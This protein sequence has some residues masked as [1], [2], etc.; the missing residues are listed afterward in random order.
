MHDLDCE[1]TNSENC[2]YDSI[3]EDKTTISRL[4]L[5][6]VITWIL[7]G[8]I[9]WTHGRWQQYNHEIA[10]MYLF[11]DFDPVAIKTFQ[12]LVAKTATICYK[13]MNGHLGF[14][15]ISVFL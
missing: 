12:I 4:L 10:Y 2:P 11:K 15:A 8:I 5:Q 6:A 1:L 14:N 13:L 7:C 3:W 9:S